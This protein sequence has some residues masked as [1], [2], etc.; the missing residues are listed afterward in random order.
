MLV[1]DPAS[2]LTPE[3]YTARLATGEYRPERTWIAQDAPGAAPRALAVWWGGPTDA[4]P[5]ALDALL[6]PGTDRTGAGPSAA[7]RGEGGQ[8]GEGG[9]LDDERTALAAELLAAAH[10]AYGHAPAYHLFLPSDWHDL[11]DT[12]AAVAWR[13][14]AARRAGLP[15]TLE[16]L[17]YEWTPSAGLPA[18]TGRLE[19]RPEPDDEV[20]VDLFRRVLA[21]TLDATSRTA[22][23]EHGAEAQARADV[24]FYRDGMSGERA[25]WRTAHTPDGEPVGFAVPSRNPASPV[26]GYLGVLPEHRGRGHAEEILAE[27]TRI[28]AAEAAAPQVRADTDLANAPMAAAFERVGYR[29]TSRRLVLTAEPPVS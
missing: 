14:E 1:T 8:D 7:E 13:R 25:W 10:A 17:R 24:A 6:V 21:G 2:T 23:A 28:L 26:V 9:R 11:P 4:E 3:T 19:F 5:A 22:A 12:R 29:T 20:F 15:G 18:P 27:T 16:R